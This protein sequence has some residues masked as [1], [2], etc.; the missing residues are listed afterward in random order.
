MLG[1]VRLLLYVVLTY[2]AGLKQPLFLCW[3]EIHSAAF[4]MNRFHTENAMHAFNL[5]V[6]LH[7][8]VQ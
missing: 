2:S 4:Y 3:Q 8:T 7:I 5:P 1:A 6:S